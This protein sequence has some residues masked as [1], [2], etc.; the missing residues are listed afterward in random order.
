MEEND[1][2]SGRPETS[3]HKLC[4]AVGN[5]CHQRWFKGLAAF[6]IL[7]LVFCL[8]AAFGEHRGEKRG[9]RGEFGSRGFMRVGNNFRVPENDQRFG[10]GM[11]QLRH[12]AWQKN[13]DFRNHNRVFQA[14]PS[15]NT[16]TAPTS[17]SPSSP[18]AGT[19]QQQ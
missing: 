19:Q 15:D 11:R 5:V 17:P 8:G 6:V 12:G 14:P 13:D 4:E 16:E 9:F 2:A 7:V 1:K 10:G 3:K 18:S